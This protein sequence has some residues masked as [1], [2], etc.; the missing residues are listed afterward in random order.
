MHCAN[1]VAIAYPQCLVVLY[2]FFV[3]TSMGVLP[4]V[5]IPLNPMYISAPLPFK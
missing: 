2:A 5:N 3:N 1:S 4:L